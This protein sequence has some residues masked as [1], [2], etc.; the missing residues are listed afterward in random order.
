MYAY[1]WQFTRFIPVLVMTYFHTSHMYNI[2]TYLCLKILQTAH[3]QDVQ[4][5]TYNMHAAHIIRQ[6][7][8]LLHIQ[9]FNSLHL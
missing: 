2:G 4:A 5:D 9:A 3:I 8:F 7:A 6:P 1:H